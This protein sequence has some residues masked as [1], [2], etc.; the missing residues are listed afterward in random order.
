MTTV[1]FDVQTN[2][3][4]MKAGALYSAFKTGL[5]Q[6]RISVGTEL[7][8]LNVLSYA[9]YEE[10]YGY[11]FAYVQTE[12]ETPTIMDFVADTADDYPHRPAGE[13]Q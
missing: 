1:N 7:E 5:V 2:A 11:A 8:A 3:L 6:I 12:T 10:G 9:N 4:D 13:Q